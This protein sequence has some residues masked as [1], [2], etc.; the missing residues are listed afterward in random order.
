MRSLCVELNERL[1]RDDNQLKAH[2]RFAQGDC[3]CVSLRHQQTSRASYLGCKAWWSFLWVVHDEV[4][5]CKLLNILN[6]RKE[7]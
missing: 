4:S 2:R 7:M 6:D 1:F 3:I 5:D